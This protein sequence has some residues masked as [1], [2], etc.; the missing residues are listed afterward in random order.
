MGTQRGCQGPAWDSY[1]KGLQLGIKGHDTGD[2]GSK[3]SRDV[4]E[5]G[6]RSALLS[7]PGADGQAGRKPPFSSS[8]HANAIKPIRVIALISELG[9]P[10]RG[11]WQGHP[12][13]SVFTG[14][15]CIPAFISLYLIRFYQRHSNSEKRA[16]QL[17][18]L[19]LSWFP[20][21]GSSLLPT[22]PPCSLTVPS[23][24]QAHTSVA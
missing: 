23:R 12:F 11:K 13:H 8:A 3:D 4:S 7:V 16:R 9:C 18:S 1:M 15:L 22:S 14:T 10:G 5:R 19:F 2:M 21:T 17:Q 24:P 20:S 6:Q